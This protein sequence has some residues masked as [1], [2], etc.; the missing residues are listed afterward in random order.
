MEEIRFTV[1]QRREETENRRV[2][3]I[4]ITD[5]SRVN[6]ARVDTAKEDVKVSIL[7]EM[8]RGCWGRQEKSI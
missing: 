2:D 6:I 5:R 3:D 8:R 7:D 4:R 1:A